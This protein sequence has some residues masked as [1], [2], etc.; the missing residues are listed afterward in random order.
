[1]DSFRRK[2]FKTIITGLIAFAYVASVYA[3]YSSLSSAILN[4]TSCAPEIAQSAVA[5][6]SE[7]LE[8]S[9]DSNFLFEYDYNDLISM[10]IDPWEVYYSAQAEEMEN[11]LV[12]EALREYY[13]QKP[14]CT[15]RVLKP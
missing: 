11:A 5:I 10:G 6:I 12:D 7:E 13:D 8:V 4:G 2:L 9:S 14:D 1:M 3:Q 15:D